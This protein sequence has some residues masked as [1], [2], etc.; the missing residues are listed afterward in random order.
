MAGTPF[1]PTYDGNV[2][3]IGADADVWGDELNTAI[4]AIA[5]DVLT[6]GTTAANSFKANNTG[7]SGGTRDIS[8]TEATALLAAV[9]GDSGSGGTKGLVPAPATGD[10]RKVLAGNGAWS[11]GVGRFAGCVITTTGV[12]G[13]TPTLSGGW[14]VASLSSVTNGGI[15]AAITVTFTDAA[16]DTAYGVHVTT[17]GADN[18]TSYGSKATGSV[19]VY[20]NPTGV[21]ELSVSIF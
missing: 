18:T 19:V 4:T 16:A 14:N 8:G 6:L 12:N 1:S 21:T 7:S 17:N 2:P 20:W 15:L 11:R 9:V 13:S 10:E 3:T 5:A